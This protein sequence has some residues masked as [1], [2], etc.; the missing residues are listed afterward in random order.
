MASQAPCRWPHGARTSERAADQRRRA[1]RR[2][3]KRRAAAWIAP[4]DA[5]IPG[6]V[7]G[8]ALNRMGAPSYVVTRPPAATMS[9]V[10]AAVS[11]SAFGERDH[12]ASARPA[13]ISA[14]L[15]ASALTTWTRNG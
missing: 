7:G 2:A 5:T 14:R 12:I 13:A 8:H 9:A 1:G 6:A 11:H 4:F 10:P 15:Y 3:T